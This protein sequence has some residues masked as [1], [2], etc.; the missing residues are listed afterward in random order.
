MIA[1]MPAVP[2]PKGFQ[3]EEASGVATLTLNRPAVLNALTFEVYAELRD[4][5]RALALRP[6][7]R[8]VVL[9]GAGRGFCSGGDVDQIIAALFEMSSAE[10]LAFTRMT[11]DVVAAMRRCPQPV[12]AALNGVAAGAGA[13]LALASDLRIAAEDSHI[14]FLFVKVGLAGADMG[15]AYLLP[16][17]IGLGRATEILLSGRKVSAQEAH[18]IGLFS[19]LARPDAVRSRAQALARELAQGPALAYQ[20]TKSL[21]NRGLELSLEGALSV[22]AEGQALCMEHPD[23]QEAYRAWREKRPP[24]FAGAPEPEEP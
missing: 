24:R 11:C 18:A 5:F 12:I 13:A 14:A 3:Y 19:E 23:F 17:L 20:M 16:R 7:V 10:R 4:T 2:A 22:E 1:S 21:L 8:A 9:T 6:Q 15:V